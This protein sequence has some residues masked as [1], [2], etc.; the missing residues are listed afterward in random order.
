MLW[1][2]FQRGRR[3]LVLDSSYD[4]TRSWRQWRQEQDDDAAPTATTPRKSEPRNKPRRAT[5]SRVRS[6][7]AHRQ[8]PAPHKI[9]QHSTQ[10]SSL[11]RVLTGT[12]LS[13]RLSCNHVAVEP[14]TKTEGVYL[15]RGCCP[16]LPA[17]NGCVPMRNDSVTSG[18]NG[19][20][21][22]KSPG[23]NRGAPRE[24]RDRGDS[25]PAWNGKLQPAPTARFRTTD[26]FRKPQSAKAKDL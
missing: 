6:Q 13:P 12:V 14:F 16:R 24:S 15:H 5:S 22:L 11:E 23:R 8:G 26:L 25:V 19:E 18:P 1:P 10:L 9:D 2:S 20:T 21:R 7:I 17:K 4:F 3:A